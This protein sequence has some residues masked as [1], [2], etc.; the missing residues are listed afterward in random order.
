MPRSVPVGAVER[1]IEVKAA[2]GTLGRPRRGPDRGR[3][4]ATA[5]GPPP[6]V[7][8]GRGRD[9]R[10]LSELAGELAARPLIAHDAKSLGGGGRTGL[11]AAAAPEA[12]ELDHDTMVAAYLIDPARRAYELAELAADE[13]S[14][15]RAPTTRR[16]AG[17]RTPPRASAG[18]PAAQARIV[19][20]LAARQRERIEELG[21]ERC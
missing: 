7:S 20:E 5:A 8:G 15:P 12:L 4:R 13:G 6:T 21:L 18:D 11:L 17:A 10:T 19:W 1:E 16:A 9:A 3:G 14:P 2:E